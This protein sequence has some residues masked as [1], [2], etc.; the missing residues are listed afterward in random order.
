MYSGHSNLYGVLQSH[1]PKQPPVSSD[2]S[3]SRVPAAHHGLLQ[4]CPTKTSW[5]IIFSLRN[6]LNIVQPA[7]AVIFSSGKCS[8][9]GVLDS[10]RSLGAKG[11][12]NKDSTSPLFSPH[13]YLHKEAARVATDAT[14][15][16]LRDLRDT[17]GHKTFLKYAI[18]LSKNMKQKSIY[19]M[20]TL[21]GTLPGS[22]KSNE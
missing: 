13:H 22:T 18:T 15:T 2:E 3:T 12:I 21:Q 8:H 7:I 16:V 20:S 14:L 19:N 11:G 4:Q 17:V 6:S 9:G 1:L 5:Y 10:S